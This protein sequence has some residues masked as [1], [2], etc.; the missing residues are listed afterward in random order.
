MPY[1]KL[2]E[3]WRTDRRTTD[4]PRKR[5]NSDDFVRGVP[6][7]P[8]VEEERREG[9]D[10]ING[11]NGKER[12]RKLCLRKERTLSRVYRKA[13]EL[14]NEISGKY[15]ELWV[16]AW[17]WDVRL[18]LTANILRIYICEQVSVL[19]TLNFITVCGE[20]SMCDTSHINNCSL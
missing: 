19:K 9:P 17:E 13:I 16:R 1:W 7:E 5:L 11:I 12:R 18:R 2:S 14:E 4:R 10:C 8:K 15:P 6:W 3:R 20:I